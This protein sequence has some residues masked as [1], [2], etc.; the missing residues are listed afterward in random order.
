MNQR[1]TRQRLVDVSCNLESQAI[2][3]FNEHQSSESNV[4]QVIDQI[5]QIVDLSSGPQTV[6]V[7]GCGP[8]P[9]TVIRL[10]EMGYDAVGLEPV[11]GL[12]AAAAVRLDDPDRIIVGGAESLP[13]ANESQQ[14]I[15]LESVLEHVDSPTLAL[16]EAYRALMP[17][18]VLYVYTTNRYRVSLTGKNGEYRTPFFNWLPALLKESF[19]FKHLHHAPHLANFSLRPAV[20]WFTNSDLCRRGREVGFAQFYSK[21]DAMSAMAGSG[22][23]HQLIRQCSK[24]AVLRSLILMQYGNSIFMWKR[25]TVQPSRSVDSAPRDNRVHTGLLAE[26]QV[27]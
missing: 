10:L 13:L 24:S 25:S 6:A 19:V 14:V 21:L 15:I 17:G 12:A 11:P 7:V 27:S 9:T 23:K 5:D 4:A 26:C 8:K 18:G 20:H 16:K 22:V 3:W 2:D 1:A